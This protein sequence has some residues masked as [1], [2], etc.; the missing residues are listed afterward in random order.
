MEICKC[1]YRSEAQE[2][3]LGWISIKDT[4]ALKRNFLKYLDAKNSTFI[5]SSMVGTGYM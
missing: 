4:L 1:Y 2:R 5:L 3:H